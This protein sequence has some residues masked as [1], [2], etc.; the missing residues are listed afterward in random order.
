MRRPSV[1]GNNQ[2]IFSAF[3]GFVVSAALGR[4]WPYGDDFMEPFRRA[5][6]RTV[7]AYYAADGGDCVCR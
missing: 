6:D 5:Q 7:L 4:R 2:G 3:G 1:H